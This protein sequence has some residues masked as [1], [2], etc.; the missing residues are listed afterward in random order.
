MIKRSTVDRVKFSESAV[1]KVENSL[2]AF[3]FR[4]AFEDDC[5]SGYRRL[6]SM[7]LL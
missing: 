1:S 7:D 6:S 5:G 3:H 2:L 4:I